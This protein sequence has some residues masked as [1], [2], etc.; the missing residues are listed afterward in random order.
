MR[1][2]SAGGPYYLCKY[3]PPP[4]RKSECSLLSSLMSRQQDSGHLHDSFLPVLTQDYIAPK[5][6]Q[7]VGL[8]WLL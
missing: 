7:V 2:S 8:G 5:Q 6:G 4:D 3:Q 1:G